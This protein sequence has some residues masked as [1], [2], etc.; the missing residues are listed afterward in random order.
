MQEFG[1]IEL[2]VSQPRYSA[3]TCTGNCSVPPLRVSMRAILSRMDTGRNGSKVSQATSS[4]G[5]GREFER[6][7][8]QV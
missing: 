3:L 1:A 5:E 4:R 7:Y 8:V 6:K 2:M